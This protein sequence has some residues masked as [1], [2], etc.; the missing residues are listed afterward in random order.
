MLVLPKMKMMK[1]NNLIYIFYFFYNSEQVGVSSVKFY[2]YSIINN[3]IFYNVKILALQTSLFRFLQQ[4]LHMKPFTIL[5]C[6]KSIKSIAKFSTAKP[7]NIQKPN[8]MNNSIYLLL[9]SLLAFWENLCFSNNLK[10]INLIKVIRSIP[11]PEHYGYAGYCYPYLPF[12]NRYQ[13]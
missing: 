8:T 11:I 5:A 1:I 7:L 10:N 2:F 4:F 9:K 13:I 12:I 6:K 3:Y